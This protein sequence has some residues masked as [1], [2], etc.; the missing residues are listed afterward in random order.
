MVARSSVTSRSIQPEWQPD[1][2]TTRSPSLSRSV[3][4]GQFRIGLAVYPTDP[5][6]NGSI[7]CLAPSQAAIGF[8]PSVSGDI[9]F[10]VSASSI[11]EW[12]R[13]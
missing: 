8:T 2:E 13:S 1:R 6:L 3:C 4:R 9:L 11:Y 12:T 10:P 5:P 7:R